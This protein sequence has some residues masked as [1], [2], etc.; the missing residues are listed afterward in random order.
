MKRLV[1]LLVLINIGLL[2]YFNL[3]RILPSTPQIKWAEIDPE[4][5]SVLSQKQIEAL[6]KKAVALPPAVAPKPTSTVKSCFEWGVFSAASLTGAQSAVEKLALQ[7]S[8]K[9][10]T[11]QQAKRFW[12]YSPP[13]KTAQ[14]AQAKAVEL[15]ALG[16][17]DLFV[18]QEQKWKNAISFGVFEDE[19]LAI[20]LMNELKAKG[21]TNVVKALRN[22]GKG[23]FSL[24]FNNV[25][26]AEV[27][28]LK[29]LKSDFPEATL[30]AV[31]CP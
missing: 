8:V 6:P 22:Q 28:S 7:A 21:V 14:E 20:K 5:I 16:V 25:A 17:E 23:H 26:D 4:K 9:E 15:K 29:Q 1:W 2:A 30:K 12:V 18:V 31:A 10:Q 11:S 13:L 3:D 27:T 24:L 19:Q